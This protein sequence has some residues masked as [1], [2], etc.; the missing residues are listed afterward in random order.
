MAADVYVSTTWI[1]LPTRTGATAGGRSL[2]GKPSAV[3]AVVRIRLLTRRARRAYVGMPPMDR[4]YP[5]RVNP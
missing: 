2:G 3:I 4:L 1:A 5:P